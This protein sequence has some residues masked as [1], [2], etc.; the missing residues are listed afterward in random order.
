MVRLN[1]VKIK[2]FR[3][4]QGEHKFDFFKDI[5]IFLGDNGNGK[6]SIFDAIQWCIS[7]KIA[8]FGN[9]ST[10][11]LRDIL[12]NNKADDCFVEMLFSNNLKLKRSISRNSNI[13]VSCQDENGR[14]VRGEENVKGCVNEAF[15]KLQNSNFDFQESLKASLLAQDQVLN[16]IANDGPKDRYRSISSIL[17][18]DEITNLKQNFEKVRNLIENKI[19]DKRK[20]EKECEEEIESQK[21]K[22]KKYKELNIEKISEFNFD[23]KQNEKIRLMKEKDQIKN[24]LDNFNL[25]QVKIGGIIQNLNL[26]TETINTIDFDIKRLKSEKEEI[27]KDCALIDSDFEQNEKNI[28]QAEKEAKLLFQNK[29]YQDELKK[30]ENKLLNFELSIEVDENIQQRLYESQ[31]SL[32]KYT[33]TLSMFKEYNDLLQNRENIPKFIDELKQKFNQLDIELQEKQNKI[34]SLKSEFLS[35]EK[36]DIDLLVKMVQEASEFVNVHKNFKNNCPVCNQRVV[37]ISKHLDER[38]DYLLHK[39]NIATERISNNKRRIK[40]VEGEILNIKDERNLTK[41]NI[42]N[43]KLQ[44][45]EVEKKINIIEGDYL[46]TKENFN[47]DSDKLILKINDLHDNIEKQTQYLQ[48]KNEKHKLKLKLEEISGMEFSGLN[49]E[50]LLEKKELLNGKQDDLLAQRKK[51]EEN[52]ERLQISLDDC[53]SMNKLINECSKFYGI[54]SNIDLS[55]FL[56]NLKD[57]KEKK[58]DVLSQELKRYEDI[59]V[60]NNLKDNLFNKEVRLQHIKKSIINLKIKYDIVGKEIT[61]INDLYSFSRIVNSNRSVIQRYFNYLN[62]NVSTYRNLYFNI[63]DKANTLDI[64]INNNNNNRTVKATS[65]L[66]SGQLNVLAIS[67]FIAKNISQFNSDIDFIAIDDPIQNMDDIN[68]FSMID[69]LSQLNK[70]VIFTTHD[71][72]YV[73]LFLKKNEVRLNDIS[74]YYL[75]AENDSYDNILESN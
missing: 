53:K 48:L 32:D 16:L 21:S 43:L 62:P 20:S 37:N 70:Q 3:N 24:T 38:V 71:A 64:E 39:I 14:I 12:I 18:M 40:E 55:K 56:I 42:S 74:V 69:V 29:K 54:S 10:E 45:E 52:I 2:N 68:Q 9:N 51:V 36:N 23:D 30:I 4:F 5:T 6:S 65:V 75:D 25:L 31:R 46:Y 63:D 66:S 58:I 60:Y 35:D 13:T 33:Y 50:R 19:S 73:N 72:K 15:K 41:S 34:I 61:H 47:L 67:I 8:R 26:I 44:Y 11:S 57:E 1:Q 27:I 49:L 59:I 22:L 7:G 17:G 28:E